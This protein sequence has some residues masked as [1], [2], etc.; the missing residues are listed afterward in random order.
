MDQI[1]P[2]LALRGRYQATPELPPACPGCGY[3]LDAAA[4][5]SAA[6]AGLAVC[7]PRQ[8]CGE[9]SRWETREG[10]PMVLERRAP[11]SRPRRP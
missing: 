9:W 8:T 4:I 1:I 11:S 10:R 7:C 5:A 2:N 6:A 3:A